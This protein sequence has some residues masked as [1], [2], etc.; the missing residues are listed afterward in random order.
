MRHSFS[1]WMQ[2][3]FFLKQ[4]TFYSNYGHFT[5]WKK[6]TARANLLKQETN[7]GWQRGR[8][9]IF[10]YT[11]FHGVLFQSIKNSSK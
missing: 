4:Y 10:L 1:L 6:K 5:L 2:L 7:S 9:I 11:Y 3:L 8:D